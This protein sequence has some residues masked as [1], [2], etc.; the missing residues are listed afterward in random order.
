LECTARAWGSAALAQLL[1]LGTGFLT[2][3]PVVSLF[4]LTVVFPVYGVLMLGLLVA[5]LSLPDSRV[6][7]EAEHGAFSGTHMGAGGIAGAL[8]GGFLYRYMSAGHV[9]LVAGVGE[10]VLVAALLLLSRTLRRSPESAPSDDPGAAPK[11]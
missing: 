6:S 4:A 3:V 2:L 8:L 7:L 9:Y 10:L 5:T 11:P 1:M